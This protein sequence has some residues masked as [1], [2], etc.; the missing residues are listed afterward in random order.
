MKTRL[1]E[2]KSD[3]VDTSPKRKED[4]E[5][6]LMPQKLPVVSPSS[7]GEDVIKVLGSSP[8]GEGISRCKPQVVPVSSN[9]GEG[10]S[11]RKPTIVAVFNP[12]DQFGFVYLYDNP[13]Q[14]VEFI[15]RNVPRHQVECLAGAIDYY[16]TRTIDATS[17]KY[18]D[19]GQTVEK[20]NHHYNLYFI[21]RFID[22]NE[23]NKLSVKH[24]IRNKRRDARLIEIIPLLDY[25]E[26]KQWGSRPSAP[27]GRDDLVV[28]I[29][30]VWSGNLNQFYLYIDGDTRNES[31]DNMKHIDLAASLQHVDDWEVSWKNGV[32]FCEHIITQVLVVP[33]TILTAEQRIT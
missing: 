13:N 26:P 32:S 7:G 8:G 31:A 14:A 18:I 11:L 6:P 10:T 15:A 22:E 28:S 16:S 24:T 33:H 9:G 19:N 30:K 23:K 25:E 20:Q 5:T 4:P 17:N 3:L 21:F 29:L 1:D 12:G 27:I 2:E